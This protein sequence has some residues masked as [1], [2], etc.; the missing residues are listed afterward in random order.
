MKATR[1]ILPALCVSLAAPAAAKAQSVVPLS[2]E[3]NVGVGVPTGD[4]SDGGSN[5]GVGFG[6][7]ATYNVAPLVG[8]RASYS[9]QNFGGEDVEELDVSGNDSGFAFGLEVSPPLVPGVNLLVYADAILHQLEGKFSSGPNSLSITSDRGLGFDI[10]AA[11]EFPIAP[12]VRI[13]PR[14]RYRQYEAEFDPNETGGFA[15][16]DVTYFAGGV[17]LKVRF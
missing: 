2:I 15:G 7:T 1:F 11:V 8:I 3:A 16:G 12:R 4:F 10:G 17:G 5:P 14:V 9:Y 6:A 13:V